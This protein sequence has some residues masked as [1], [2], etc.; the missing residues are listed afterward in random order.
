MKNVKPG[1]TIIQDQPELFYAVFGTFIIANIVLL[2]LGWAAIR[3]ASRLVRIPRPVLLPAI[4]LF[5]AVGA[6]AL[7]NDIL[8]VWIR[9][10]F[11]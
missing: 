5:C 8:D 7:H 6:Y 11:V 3:A 1:P 10:N 4:L 9:N 2:P